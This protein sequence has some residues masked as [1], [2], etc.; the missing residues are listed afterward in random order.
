MS[1]RIAADLCIIGAGSGGLSVA[2]GAAQMG[3]RTVLVERARMGGECLNTG[4]VPSKSLI[5]AAKHAAQARASAAFGVMLPEPAIDFAAVMR[6]VQGVI[7]AL[8]PQDSAERFAGLGVRVIRAEARFAAP[9]EVTA[10]DLSIRARRIV[11]A[12]GSAPT[13]PPIPGLDAAPFFTNE[14]IFENSVR[15]E[16]LVVIGGGPVGLELAQAH[17]LLGS[18]VTVL[19]AGRALAKDDP[20]LAALLLERLR[21]DGIHL[22][23]GA[24]VLRV[25]RAGAEVAV[26]FDGGAGEQRI[27][28]SHLLIAAGRRATLAGLALDKAGIATDAKG[29]LVLDRRLRT[30]NR[31]VY[32]VGDAAGGPQF[33]H[34]ATYQAGIVIRNALFRLPAKVDYRAMPWATYTAPELAQVGMTEAQ[35]RERY[36][37][38]VTILRSP[39]FDNDRAHAERTTAGLVKVVTRRNGRILGASILGAAAGE[40][41]A[42][43]GLAIEGRVKLKT[44]AQMI[45][46]YPTFSEASKR[47]AGG[48][49]APRLFGEG[50]RRLVRFLARFG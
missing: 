7:A 26:A 47:A 13:V 18:R 8:A 37:G 44:I 14:T 30:T 25:E 1:E 48:F 40:L 22:I 38:D 20:E 12:T 41:V 50:T 3:A 4:C 15:P 28:A 35:A 23:E 6:H 49:Y 39:F 9:D 21:A 45:A 5:A 17:R 2:A 36:G 43:W 16:H 11:I 10:G 27:A 24:R 34:A 33:T 19:E 32:A 31:H 42:L 29:A 46:P